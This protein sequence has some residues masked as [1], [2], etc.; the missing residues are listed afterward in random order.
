MKVLVILL[1]IVGGVGAFL[2]FPRGGPGTP[3]T[4]VA[5]LATPNTTIDGSRAAAAF[6]PA[7]DGE[8]YATGDLVRANVD[9]RAVLTFFDASSL[10]VDPG[11]QVKVIALNRLSAMTFTCEPGST[12]RDEA[13][14]NVR[15]ARPSTLARTRSPVA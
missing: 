14:K 9:G 10:S 12:D 7:L 8:I 4:S 11:S 15:T 13:S 3:A 1:L 5:T 2:Y 6:A